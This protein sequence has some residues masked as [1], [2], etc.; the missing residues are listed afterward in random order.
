MKIQIKEAKQINH[1]VSGLT[2]L[3]CIMVICKCGIEHV[4]VPGN[5]KVFDS[6]DEMAG[7]YWEC[8]CKSTLFLP[9]DIFECRKKAV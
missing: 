3:G 7:I 4:G 9:K 2:E 6:G 8:E 1:Q 5:A